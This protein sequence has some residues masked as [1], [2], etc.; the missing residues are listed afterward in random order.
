MDILKGLD[1]LH[2]NKIIHRD[3]KPS[4]ILVSSKGQIKIT[5][6]GLSKVYESSEM[7]PT[8]LV[9]PSSKRSNSW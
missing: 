6:F 4:N 9:R 7:K 5:D 2:K 8:A 1:F 3:L